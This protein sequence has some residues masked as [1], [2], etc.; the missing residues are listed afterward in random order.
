MEKEPLII[1]KEAEVFDFEAMMNLS[2]PAKKS[3]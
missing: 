3:K 1:Q 2:Q